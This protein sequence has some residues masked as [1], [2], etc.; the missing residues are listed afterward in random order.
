MAGVIKYLLTVS[1][2]LMCCGCSPIKRSTNQQDTDCYGTDCYYSDLDT[3]TE[4]VLPENL[5]DVVLVNLPLISRNQDEIVSILDDKIVSILDDKIV[6]IL[7]DKIVSILDNQ[8]GGITTQMTIQER[9][10]TLLSSQV[11]SLNTHTD[12]QNQIV[13]ILNN[14]QVTLDQIAS[15]LHN[16]T[17]SLSTMIAKHEQMEKLLNNINNN[18]IARLTTPTPNEETKSRTLNS[19]LVSLTTWAPTEETVARQ[20]EITQSINNQQE[21]DRLRDCTDIASYNHQSRPYRI[22]PVG[23]SESYTV[24]C[25]LETDGGGWTV[26]Q[27]RFNGSVDFYRDWQDYVDGF[28]D[29][30]GEYW[31][32]LELIHLL[33]KTG[34]W[35]LRVD[36]EDFSHTTVYAHYASF[37]VGNATSNYRLSL[38]TYS[39]TAGDGMKFDNG[40]QFSTRDNENDASQR[41]HCAVHHKGAWWYSDCSTANLNGKYLGPGQYDKEGLTWFIWRVTYKVLKKSEMKIRRI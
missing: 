3:H 1:I 20:E 23:A 11:T 19:Q 6:S 10:A 29:P 35:E 28:G 38:G 27:R 7:N 26:I 8:M 16:I 30:H 22:T 36:L 31:A 25:D 39:G 32:G 2:L 24:R 40:N 12:N 21:S 15:L 18:D 5:T 33:T 17:G 37:K 13:S 4:L 14:Q 34:A 9:I 41:F